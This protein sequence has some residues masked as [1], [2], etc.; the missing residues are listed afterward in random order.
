MPRLRDCRRGAPHASTRPRTD[1]LRAA[2][3][4]EPSRP[5][6]GFRTLRRHAPE[7]LSCPSSCPRQFFSIACAER[8]AKPGR[9]VPVQGIALNARKDPNQRRLDRPSR[10]SQYFMSAGLRTFRIGGG[11]FLVVQRIVP[12]GDPLP[13]VSRH[14]VRAVRALSGFIASYRHER[15]L[16]LPSLI[17]IQML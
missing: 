6:A 16:P 9:I 3:S 4:A 2:R 13:D 12:I 8:A 17:V 7:S 5:R 1:G 15:L 11:A 10:A 14:V